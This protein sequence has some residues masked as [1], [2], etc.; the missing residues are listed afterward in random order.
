METATPLIATTER[1][2]LRELNA[3]DLD[4]LATMLADPET[5][6]FY[7]QPLDRDAAQ[8]WLDRQLRRYALDGHGLWLVTDRVAGSALGQVGLVNHEV[9]GVVEHEI[10]Y[11]IHHPHWRQGYATEAA[12]AVRSLARD[13]FGYDRVISLIRPE[14]L[15]SQGVARRLGM[16]AEKSVVW[17]DLEHIVFGTKL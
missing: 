14:N 3:V 17:H 7:P 1:L 10:G 9:D 6:R 5:M 13:R 16:R 15:P 2:A 11:L 4:F 12:L 8:Q